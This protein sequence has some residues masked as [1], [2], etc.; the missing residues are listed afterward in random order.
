MI[1]SKLRMSN[2]LLL[3]GIEKEWVPPCKV[4]RNWSEQTRSLLPDSFLQ[5]HLGVGYLNKD[6]VLSDA[7]ARA[8]GIED[9]G[10][11]ILLRVISSLSNSENVLKSMG[12]SWLSSCLSAIYV[13]LC[14]S[15][16]ETSP[17]YLSESDIILSLKKIPFIPVLDGKFC[18][19]DEDTIWLHIEDVGHGCNDDYVKL[20]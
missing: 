11:K 15:G 6:I 10:P 13:M 12:M 8:L 9:Y 7:L 1:V 3:E 16:N 18:S 20:S 5:E 14:H 19:V 17:S 2:C 4:L